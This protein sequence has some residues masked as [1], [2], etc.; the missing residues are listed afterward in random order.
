MIGVS[1]IRVI[2]QR[3]ERMRNPDH[4]TVSVTQV[5]RSN[6]DKLGVLRLLDLFVCLWD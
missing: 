2:I 4:S 5:L 6:F 3:N 1:M